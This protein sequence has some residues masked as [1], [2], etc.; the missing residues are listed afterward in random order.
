MVK[1]YSTPWDSRKFI[2]GD[3][4][5]YPY[6][7]EEVI[8]YRKTNHERFF[9]DE[10]TN[11]PSV[12][13][14]GYIA[15]VNGMYYE[16]NASEKLDANTHG[17]YLGF[18]QT[19][20]DLFRGD[21]VLKVR[22]PSRTLDTLII[23]DEDRRNGTL[24]NFNGYRNLEQLHN[25]VGSPEK[26]R[27][28]CLATVNNEIDPESVQFLTQ[29]KV[30][31]SPYQGEDNWVEGVWDM[32]FND[33]PAFQP[34]DR[35]LSVLKNRYGDKV[36]Y[37][38]ATDVNQHIE[39]ELENLKKAG[40]LVEELLYVLKAARKQLNMSSGLKSR[41][42]LVESYFSWMFRRDRSY[43]EV[44]NQLQQLA[45]KK[46][47]SQDM[48][49]SRPEFRSADEVRSEMDDLI[50]FCESLEEELKQ[51]YH[52]EK[53]HAVSENWNRQNIRQESQ[54]EKKFE[55]DLCGKISRLPDMLGAAQALEQD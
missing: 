42:E 16:G 46:F 1:R 17:V 41:S 18:L 20:R 9:Q 33:R 10:F 52:D 47:C 30:P 55:K 14:Q 32:E 26:F 38:S 51:L 12:I 25:Y 3:L 27:E 21:T 35:Y 53:K 6:Q 11:Q 7:H 48:E 44:R 2:A 5:T 54:F 24:L 45:A 50:S 37:T 43:R 28:I 8:L 49:P 23:S 15:P 34:L 36:A 13:E 29:G 31:V 22:V 19:T 40:E 39:T 4:V